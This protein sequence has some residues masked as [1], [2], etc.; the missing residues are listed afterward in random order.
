M[1]KHG[2]QVQPVSQQAEEEWRRFSEA[3]YPKIRGDIV[4][5]DMFDEV[6][7]VLR[8]YRAAQRASGK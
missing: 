6:V 5:A 3:L 7:D 1:E 4:P 8:D 2:L